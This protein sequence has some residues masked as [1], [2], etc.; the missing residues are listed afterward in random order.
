VREVEPRRFGCGTIGALGSRG[1]RG[2]RV[3][4]MARRGEQSLVPR[5]A[6][7]RLHLAH[8]SGRAIAEATRSADTQHL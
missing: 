4:S 1:V 7:R 3:A 2:R 5:S 8:P 6:M